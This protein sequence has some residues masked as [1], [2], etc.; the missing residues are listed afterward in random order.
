MILSP[1]VIGSLEGAPR[2]EVPRLEV[3]ASPGER[4]D[5]RTSLGAMVMALPHKLQTTG[6]PTTVGRRRALTRRRL[7]SPLA[8]RSR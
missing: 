3:D 2:V 7:A 4:G 1:Y 6:L 5:P 8:G